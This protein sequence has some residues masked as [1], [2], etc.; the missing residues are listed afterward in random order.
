[1]KIIA[2]VGTIKSGAGS[3]KHIITGVTPDLEVTGGVEATIVMD[4]PYKDFLHLTRAR[5]NGQSFQVA[6]AL[7]Q[8]EMDLGDLPEE[9]AAD[10]AEFAA[11]FKKFWEPGTEEGEDN[12]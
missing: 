6:I 2:A 10:A 12:A 8:T 5:L 7:I 11:W 9:D 4:I 3:L 1:M